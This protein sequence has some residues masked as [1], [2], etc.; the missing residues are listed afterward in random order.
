MRDV[1]PDLERLRID[2]LGRVIILFVLQ[3]LLALLIMF[4]AVRNYGSKN[5]NQIVEW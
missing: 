2:V 3:T 5:A 4:E 1:E